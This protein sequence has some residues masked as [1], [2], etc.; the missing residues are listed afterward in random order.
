[1]VF[2]DVTKRDPRSLGD[3]ECSAFELGIARARR[4][5]AAAGR[6]RS[7]R[8]RGSGDAERVEA[9]TRRSRALRPLGTVELGTTFPLL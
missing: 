9:E 5:G 2:G 7:A 3:D 4:Q 6:L 1:M 8:E